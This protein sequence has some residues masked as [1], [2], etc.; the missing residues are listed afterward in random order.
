MANPQKENGYTAIANELF[1]VLIS[2]RIPGEL[3]QVFD[4]IIR[5]TYGYN[6]KEDSIANSQI[7]VATGLKKGN[8]SRSLKRL[9]KSKLVIKTDNFTTGHKL[10]INKDYSEWISFVIKTDN[11]KKLSKRKPKLSKRITKVIRSDNKKLSEVR[12]TKD[13]TILKDN[14]QKT[15]KISKEILRGEQW[16]ELIDPFEKVNPM[17]LKFY[18]NKT[19]RHALQEMANAIGYVKL[20]WLVDNLKK[21]VSV[22]FAPKITRPVELRRDM[23][24]LIVFWEQEKARNNKGGVASIKNNN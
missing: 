14:I 4:A 6:K 23:G 8:V 15:R 18:N 17:Y 9:I 20:K 19:E 7:I 3:R 1:D 2:F 24:K 12:D 11:K 5:K 13:K 10:K 22:P 16:N 21:A